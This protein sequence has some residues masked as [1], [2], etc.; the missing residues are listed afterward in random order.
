MGTYNLEERTTIF[1]KNILMF[2]RKVTCDGVI[3]SLINQLIRSA[4]SIGANY[5]EANGADSRK[6]FRSKISICKKEAKETMYWLELL[7]S[8]NHEYVH[9]LQNLWN[10]S[11]ELVMIFVSIGKK[12]KT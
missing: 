10:E 5:R 3:D 2:C 6:D 7:K 4:T 9:E 11:H 12:L 1:S 8:M